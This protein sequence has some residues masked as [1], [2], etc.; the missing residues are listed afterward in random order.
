MKFVKESIEDILKPKKVD[1]NDLKTFVEKAQSFASGL[2]DEIEGA[3]DFSYAEERLM[4]L[5][6]EIDRWFYEL[7]EVVQQT[8]EIERTWGILHELCDIAF[9][10]AR[11]ND[12]EVTM[13]ESISLLVEQKKLALAAG[14][15]II[16][17]GKILLAHPTNAKW[18]GTFSIPKGHVEEGEELIDA[19]IRETRE[20]VGIK[21]N[22]DD[23]V[24][25]PY[26]VDYTDKKGKLYKRV[27]Y[28]V[29]RPSEKIKPGKLQKA[30]IDWAG[31]MTK[32]DAKKRMLGKL[33]GILKHVK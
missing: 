1:A 19:A 10:S 18:T 20:E 6:D 30:E 12:E 15:V 32:A 16:Q 33:R 8:P 21:I 28:Y 17:D 5:Y 24:G 31:F 11:G 4:Q 23:I 25:G 29:V 3:A 14:L 26:F 2:A 27:Y 13:S 9:A 22:K 7:P